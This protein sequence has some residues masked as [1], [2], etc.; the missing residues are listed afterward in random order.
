MLQQVVSMKD[1]KTAPIPAH[2]KVGQ[3]TFFEDT[4]TLGPRLLQYVAQGK[5]DKARKIL[6]INPDLVFY[7]GQVVDY[8]DRTL[9]GAPYHIAL[10]AEDVAV[11]S[12]EGMA[13]MIRGYFLKVFDNNEEHA[14]RA[15]KKQEGEQFPTGWEI[16]EKERQTKDIQALQAVFKAIQDSKNDNDCEE[17]LQK[18][19]EYLKP[20]EII[21]Q[22]KHFNI[23]LMIKAFELFDRHYD[24]F[25]G[26]KGRKNILFWRKVIG[27]IQ[28]YLPACYAQIFCSG[29]YRVL[30]DYKGW[31]RDTIFLFNYK[32]SYY[33]LDQH[34]TFRLGYEYAVGARAY[35][36]DEILWIPTFNSVIV[37]WVDM[38]ECY[39]L[40][41]LVNKKKEILQ[42]F[43]N[44]ESM[45]L[46]QT[47][48]SDPGSATD[49]GQKSCAIM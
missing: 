42:K 39:G 19:R 36:E 13:E 23:E 5:I 49:N 29:L 14:M 31:W 12:S 18:F 24:K 15:I 4:L 30:H 34:S 40:Q 16:K 27:Y 28:R 44:S 6:D 21:K 43:L 1:S 17:A 2:S 46:Q 37:P 8:S 10:G 25:G 41:G 33:P 32:E 9:E 20:K 47:A 11:Y 26:E 22:G 38:P 3:F 45:L 35:P 7:R 48:S